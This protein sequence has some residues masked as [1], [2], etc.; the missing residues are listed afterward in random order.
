MFAVARN[1]RCT[2]GAVRFYSQEYE[3]N[4]YHGD[5]TRPTLFETEA[6]AQAVAT[7]MAGAERK[8]REWFVLSFVTV[9]KQAEPVPP[10]VTVTRGTPSIVRDALGRFA[11]K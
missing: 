8:G 11:R 6:E 1:S 7:R 3:D 2:P 4:R 10:P 5:L 9:T